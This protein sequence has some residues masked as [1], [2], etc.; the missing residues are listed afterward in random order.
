MNLLE[1]VRLWKNNV[2]DAI[3]EGKGSYIKKRRPTP[4]IER[5]IQRTSSKKSDGGAWTQLRKAACCACT[6]VCQYCMCELWQTANNG[7]MS[8]VCQTAQNEG[9]KMGQNA[10]KPFHTFDTR[11]WFDPR[12]HTNFM[13]PLPLCSFPAS[14]VTESRVTRERNHNLLSSRQGANR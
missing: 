9:A 7:A 11:S 8:F 2:W 10:K 6:A 13:A 5:C 14:N 4:P 3:P 12:R 1:H